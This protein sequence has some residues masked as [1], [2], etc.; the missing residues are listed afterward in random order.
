MT[1]AD[2]R[3]AVGFIL[4]GGE[5]SDAVNGRLLLDAIG[6]IKDPYGEEPLFL[7]ND[8]PI[9]AWSDII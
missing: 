9:R 8:Y 2:N 1:A 4:S 6:R 3:C 7:L 5:A